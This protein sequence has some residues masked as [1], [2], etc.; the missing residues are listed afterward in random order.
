M[1]AA[2]LF[3]GL[4]NFLPRNHSQYI[5]AFLFLAALSPILLTIEIY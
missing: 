4:L 3:S 2:E 1:F 5:E